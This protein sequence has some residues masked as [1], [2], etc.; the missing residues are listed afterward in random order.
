M[1]GISGCQDWK[2]TGSFVFPETRGSAAP[3]DTKPHDTR[4]NE[5]VDQAT[6]IGE[7]DG[8]ILDNTS[9]DPEIQDRLKG[10]PGGTK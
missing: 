3:A 7:A 4:G 6:G 1:I 2:V 10:F 9:I 8:Q 5:T